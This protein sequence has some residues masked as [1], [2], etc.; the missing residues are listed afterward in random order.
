MVLSNFIRL[1]DKRVSA[2]LSCIV[3]GVFC[4]LPAQSGD[5]KDTKDGTA[6]TERTRNVETAE[7]GS[8]DPAMDYV[9]D[10]V[11]ATL[12]HELAHAIIEM[13]EVPI[14]GQE[15]DAA[16][17]LSAIMIN[18]RHSEADAVRIAGNSIQSFAYDADE[19]EAGGRELSLWDVHGPSRQRYYNTICIFYGAKPKQRTQFAEDLG[20]PE[21][22]AE[23]C[24]DEYEM[25][26]RGWD[27]ILERIRS[28]EKNYS[29]EF[30]HDT[31]TDV[32]RL[33]AKEL[34]SM[35]A[36]LNSDFSLPRRLDIA[37]K[38]CGSE[39]S[40]YQAYYSLGPGGSSKI[41][42]CREYISD[43]YEVASNAL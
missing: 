29:I 6:K 15:E 37:L 43:L 34:E 19:E 39:D 20:L 24:P 38:R 11:R 36:E 1:N 5:K 22:R 35:I 25:A 4:G 7:T 40:G 42:F 8:V 12:Y 27:P 2:L 16:D 13:L 3:I 14:L 18:G 32:G 10:N 28:A 26:A 9:F 23:Y 21:D 17:V 33:V 41:T 30:R 31:S